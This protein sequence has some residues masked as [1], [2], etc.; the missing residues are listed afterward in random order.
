MV[1]L[2]VKIAKK[3]KSTVE[4]FNSVLDLT[5]ME[6]RIITFRRIPLFKGARY[7]QQLAR[8]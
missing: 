1:V 2:A 5:R 7:L 6:G 4:I 8:Y 3:T